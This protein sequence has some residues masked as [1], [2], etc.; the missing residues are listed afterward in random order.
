MSHNATDL[1]AVA[2]ALVLEVN[3]TD[4]GL[5]L[6]TREIILLPLLLGRVPVD[7]VCDCVSVPSSLEICYDGG[8]KTYIRK[9]GS[10]FCQSCHSP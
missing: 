10:S 3:D 6:A 2:V 8:E 7:G 5:L 1:G 4:R 9:A